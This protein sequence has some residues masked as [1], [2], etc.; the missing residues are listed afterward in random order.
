MPLVV[1]LIPARAGN[2]L[3]APSTRRIGAAH[4]RSRGEHKS[5]VKNSHGTNGSSPL[6]RGTSGNLS[7]KALNARLIPARA[8]NMRILTLRTR[9]WS[10]H[11]RSRGEH[12][13][14]RRHIQASLGSSPLAR[15]TWCGAW[16]VSW[17]VRL[18]PA[19]AGN[20]AGRGFP[21]R[22]GAAHPRSRGEHNSVNIL[23]R[24]AHGSSPLARGTCLRF[25][26]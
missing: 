12:T 8:G 7:P 17:L 24:Y 23:S 18:I 6:A 15:G 26:Q 9:A 25:V 10:A 22:G 3:V 20:I 19:R 5:E 13:V 21:W 4:P 16:V 1:R 14:T 2:I 11:P